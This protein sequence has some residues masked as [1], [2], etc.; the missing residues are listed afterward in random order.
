MRIRHVHPFH[1]YFRN[2]RRGMTLIEI[3][4]VITIIVTLMGIL[5]YNVLARLDEAKV[6]TSKI[7]MNQIEQ[8]LQMYALKHNGHY[9]TTS[10]GLQSASRYMPD[11][12]K[13]PKDGWDSDFAYFCPGTHGS[14]DFELVSWGK[15]GKEGGDGVNADIYSWDD[16]KDANK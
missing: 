5:G 9:P 15:D 8:A 16:N 4:V 10:D 2:S 13:L 3:M 14:H 11:P 7:T 12:G 1:G 6:E